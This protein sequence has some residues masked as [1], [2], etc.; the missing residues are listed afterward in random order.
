MKLNRRPVTTWP[1]PWD[2]VDDRFSNRCS[3]VAQSMAPPLFTKSA[4]SN[5]TNG[6]RCIRTAE[7]KCYKG[8]RPADITTIANRFRRHACSQPIGNSETNYHHS[9]AINKQSD[10]QTN[11][12][13]NN[14]TGLLEYNWLDKTVSTKK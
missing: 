12:Q 4:D 1:L 6:R 8:N 3:A 7:L 13:I 5:F 9:G 14:K 11:K 2:L 10:K